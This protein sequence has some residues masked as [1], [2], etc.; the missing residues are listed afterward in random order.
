M[1]EVICISHTAGLRRGQRLLA[2]IVL[3]LRDVSVVGS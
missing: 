2:E 3:R 1:E